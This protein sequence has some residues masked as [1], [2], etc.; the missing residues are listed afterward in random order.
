MSH[1]EI[2]QLN[3]TRVN[4][5]Q[6]IKSSDFGLHFLGWM[7]YCDHMEE[8]EGKELS[9]TLNGY[10][11]WFREDFRPFEVNEDYIIFKEGFKEGYARDILHE[12][13]RIGEEFLPAEVIDGS[14]LSS[15]RQLIGSPVG[16]FVYCDD[17]LIPYQRWLLEY[18]EEEKKYYLGAVINYHF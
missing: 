17:L 16:P 14:V 8:M 4:Q 15:I 6:R 1:G 10:L 2:I 7:E 9:A 13:E 11:D 3:Q 12:L 5:E 18:M